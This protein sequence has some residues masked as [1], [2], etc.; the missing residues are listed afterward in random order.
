MTTLTPVIT[1][2]AHLFEE[3]EHKTK[4]R[5]IHY[6]TGLNGLVIDDRC[7]AGNPEELRNTHYFECDIKN[8]NNLGAVDNDIKFLK[9]DITTR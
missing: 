1:L 2:S 3:A 4:K 5:M 7:I 8:V 9:R 6:D